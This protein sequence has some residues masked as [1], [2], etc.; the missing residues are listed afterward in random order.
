M[1]ASASDFRRQLGQLH[2]LGGNQ[3][4]LKALDDQ[5]IPPQVEEFMCARTATLSGKKRS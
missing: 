1:S 5:M 4:I 2:V 3:Q